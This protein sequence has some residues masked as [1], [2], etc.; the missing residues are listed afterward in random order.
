D[1][2]TESPF[3]ESG[4]DSA[5]ASIPI[6]IA[7]PMIKK[8]FSPLLLAVFTLGVIFIGILVTLGILLFSQK[9]TTKKTGKGAKGNIVVPDSGREGKPPDE[10]KDEQ[11]GNVKIFKLKF[12]T[13]PEGAHIFEGEDTLCVSPCDVEWIVTEGEEETSRTFSV[14]KEGYEPMEIPQITPDSDVTIGIPLTLIEEEKKKKAPKP[15]ETEDKTKK[16][17]KEE[18]K[19][20]VK[21][22]GSE[23]TKKPPDKEKKDKGSE[24]TKKPPDKEKKDKGDKDK[25][26]KEKEKENKGLKL[27]H[28]YPDM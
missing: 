25:E 10:I 11:K 8:K 4:S 7:Q 13:D 21:D 5:S 15:L 28:D 22:K 14:V 26:D 12:E 27:I 23:S 17:S 3:Y 18:D 20:P 1:T 2:L 9:S 16:D 24:A 19:T 6:D